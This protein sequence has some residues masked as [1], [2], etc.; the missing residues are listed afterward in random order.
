MNVP[1]ILSQ[2]AR[3]PGCRY[4]R[5]GRDDVEH[6]IPLQGS[7]FALGVVP[8]AEVCSVCGEEPLHIYRWTE[9]DGTEAFR[10]YPARC[11]CERYATQ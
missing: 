9:T 2:M 11:D 6:W 1:A 7:R 3:Y 4:I 8:R 10:P 5:G